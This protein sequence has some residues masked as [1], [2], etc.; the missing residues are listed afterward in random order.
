MFV[1]SYKWIGQHFATMN[2]RRHVKCGLSTR[3]VIKK[4]TTVNRPVVDFW[5]FDVAAAGPTPRVPFSL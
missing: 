2:T 1:V 4:Y 5:Q 3:S